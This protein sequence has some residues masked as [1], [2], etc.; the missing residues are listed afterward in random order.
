M[1][2]HR[3]FGQMPVSSCWFLI[4]R[5]TVFKVVSAL[6]VCWWK[7]IT[8]CSAMLH[9]ETPTLPKWSA[10][11]TSCGFIP[12]L[13]T[14]APGGIWRHRV[15]QFLGTKNILCVYLYIYYNIYI[16]IY[17]WYMYI[18]IYHM[19]ISYIY[20]YIYVCVYI[21]SG[22]IYIYTYWIFEL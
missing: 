5:D 11:C 9:A 22:N 15:W 18:Y 16:Y 12:F 21:I 14:T 8:M 10:P 1:G 6:M 4:H 19:C 7:A 2:E 13:L 20:I 17:T 3:I